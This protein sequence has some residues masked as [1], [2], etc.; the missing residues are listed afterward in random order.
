M[1][2]LENVIQASYPTLTKKEENIANYLLE[3]SEEAKEQSISEIAEI[4][5]VAESTVFLFAKKIGLSGFK[6]LTVLLSNSSK[7]IIFEGIYGEDSI[8]TITKKVV[9]SATQSITDAA[10]LIDFEELNGAVNLLT[11]SKKVVFFAL[12][13]SA[14]IALDAYHKFLRSPLDVEY[15]MD[16]HMQLLK[17]GKLSKDNCAVIISHSGENSDILRISKILK[18]NNVPTIVISSFTNTSLTKLADFTF[19]APSEEL[20]YNNVGIYT[21]RMAQLLIIDILFTLVITSS[22]DKS[23]PSFDKIQSALNLTK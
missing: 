14:P 11:E 3:Y 20:K 10:S 21:R 12:G 22:D 23:G 2:Y 1:T 9:E 5:H 17:A 19:I 4:C 8:Q 13:G 18:E 15:N 6:E 7:K 16:Y